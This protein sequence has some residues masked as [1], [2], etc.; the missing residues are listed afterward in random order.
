MR[1]M[2]IPHAGMWLSD[3]ALAYIFNGDR[4]ARFYGIVLFGF[5]T[6]ESISQGDISTSGQDGQSPHTM[7]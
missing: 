4:P 7:N 2:S 6:V 3:A 1:S 5:G